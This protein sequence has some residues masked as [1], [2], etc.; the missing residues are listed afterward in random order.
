MRLGFIKRQQKEDRGG[1]ETK[2]T[3]EG[4]GGRKRGGDCE[5]GRTRQ[6]PGMGYMG[7]RGKRGKR[8][9]HDR[10]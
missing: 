7:G 2:T 10:E 1:G 5:G 3:T 9:R 8:Q 4:R 6:R